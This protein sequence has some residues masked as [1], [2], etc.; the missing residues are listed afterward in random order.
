IKEYGELRF[1]FRHLPLT[2]VHPHA[3]LAAEAA[4]AA[5]SQGKFWEMHDALMDHQGA[6][7]VQD[8]LGYAADIGLDTDKFSADLRAHDYTTARVAE[9]VE[10]ADLDTV[11]G[12]PTFFIN[13]RRYYGTYD[14][15]TLMEAVRTAKAIAIIAQ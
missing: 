4:E 5:A 1:V 12:T 13:G 15:D 6:L 2:D 14:L 11:S 3:Q 10:S 7:T 8:L 9:D